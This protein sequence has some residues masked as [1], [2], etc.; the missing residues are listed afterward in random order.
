MLWHY[1]LGHPNFLYLEKLF[2]HLFNKNSK[3]FQCEVCQLSNHI[4]NYYP[5]QPYKSSHPF[6]LIHSD[7]WGPSRISNISGSRWF[8]TFI[9]DH[10]RITWLFFMKEKSE[11]GKNFQMFHKMIQINFKQKF[12]SSKLIM[13]GNTFILNLALTFKNKGLSLLVPV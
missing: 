7:V 6:Y 12:K 8:V 11:V 9:D 10:T 4:C 2:P 3:V 1:R 13:E 5:H